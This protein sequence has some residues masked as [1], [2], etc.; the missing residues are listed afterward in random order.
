M[1]Q[2]GYIH[3]TD[4]DEQRRLADLNTILNQ[5]SLAA[6]APQDGEHMLEVGCG[7]G[8]FAREVA[9]RTGVPVVGVERSAAQ[10]ARAR[11]LAIADDELDMLELR[12]GAAEALPLADDE[13]GRFDVVHARFLLEHVPDPQAV[14]DQMARAVRPG[15]RVVVEDDDHAALRL[16]PE[17]AGLATV[18]QA[19]IRTYDR[20][21]CDPFV[22]RRLVALLAAAG[23]RPHRIELLRFGACAGEPAFPALVANLV[24]ILLGARTA[25]LD[26][27]G[28]DETAFDAAIAALRA[29]AQRADAALWYS[30][31]WAEA[32][33]PQ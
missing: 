8:H 5:I 9:N 29:F 28:C 13:W 3:G 4:P 24:D 14:V 27:A 17:P 6:L 2:G 32:L 23:L 1:S 12:A 25:I 15:G 16:W 10:L 21:G 22:G 19:Y 11:E 26:T 20:L 18:W 31:S 33:R 7:L 30:V